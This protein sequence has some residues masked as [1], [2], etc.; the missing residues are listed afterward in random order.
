[1]V[2]QRLVILILILILSL[3]PPAPP[4]PIPPRR[5]P[6][7]FLSRNRNLTFFVL[8]PRRRP[9]SWPWLISKRGKPG[10]EEVGTSRHVLHDNA[11]KLSRARDGERSQAP[12]AAAAAHPRFDADSGLGLGLGVGLALGRRLATAAAGNTRLKR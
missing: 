9:R 3:P 6:P 12:A 8:L 7:A 2:L 5:F 11:D 4:T 10:G 1:M